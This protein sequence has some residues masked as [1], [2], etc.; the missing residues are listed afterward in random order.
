MG[1]TR[2]QDY[3]DKFADQPIR[4]TP[5]ALKKTG[6]VQSQV[7]LK[8]EEYHLICAPF[9]LSMHRGVFLVVLSSQE[10]SFFQQFQRKLCSIN[11]TFQRGSS[12]KPLTFLLRGTLERVGALK[13]RQNVCMMDALFK[14]SPPPELVDI[15][16]EYL[17]AFAALHTLHEGFKDRRIAVDETAAKVMRFNNYMEVL[18]GGSKVRAT[19]LT[20]SVHSLR[21]RL[22]MALPALAVG[23]ACSVRLYFQIYQFAVA[24]KVTAMSPYDA[25]GQCIAELDLDFSPELVE[26]VDDYV[27]RQS[28]QGRKADAQPAR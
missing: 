5:Y 12:K 3:I 1:K 10:I 6:L 21:L 15:I 9:Q 24:G 23:V 28:I 4:F 11:L 25:S 7:F 2:L 13:G 22:S 18:L 20:L 17:A 19:L 16:G 26:I 27:F 14:G 8:I